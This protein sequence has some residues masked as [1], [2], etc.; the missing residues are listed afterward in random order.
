VRSGWRADSARRYRETWARWR[1]TTDEAFA[2]AVGRCHFAADVLREL[3]FELSGGNYAAVKRHLRRLGLDTSDWLKGR[4]PTGKPVAELVALG[5][6]NSRGYIKRRLIKAGVLRNECYE[7][8]QHP[9]W[10]GKPLVLVLDH[11][12]GVSDDYRPENLRLLCPNCNSQTSTFCG[13]NMKRR[14]RESNGSRRQVREALTIYAVMGLS[15][16][17]ARE[18]PIRLPR[19]ATC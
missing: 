7:C 14:R 18:I 10:R 16:R 3:G 11:I 4:P 19:T 13:R 15:T 9:T 2:A 17:S 1:E 5:G 8:Q 12:N 6:S